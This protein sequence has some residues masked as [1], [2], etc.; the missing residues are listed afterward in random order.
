MSVEDP[1]DS[2][3]D[4]EA[5]HYQAGFKDGQISAV[6]DGVI[7]HGRRAGFMKGYAIGLE[8]GFMESS[9]KHLITSQEQALQNHDAAS[10]NGTGRLTKRRTEL[11]ERCEQLPMSNVN[12]FDFPNEV[13]Q[14]R[15]IYKQCGSHLDFLPKNVKEANPTQEW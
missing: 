10:I 1:W 13:N 5:Q 6:E 11:L 4:I 2:V 12:T 9:V 15:T 3:L 8:V 14:I 7:N